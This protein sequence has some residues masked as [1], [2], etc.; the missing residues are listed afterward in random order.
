MFWHLTVCQQNYIIRN[1]I[2]WNRTDSHNWIASNRC[3]WQLNCVLILNCIVWNRTVYLYKNR[4]GI[5]ITYKGWYA[6]KPK[7]PNQPSP[8]KFST[9][10]RIMQIT[11]LLIFHLL[12][13]F[14]YFFSFSFSYSFPLYFSFIFPTSLSHF[15]SLAQ[16]VQCSPLVRET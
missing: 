2:V 14:F 3:F 15:F 10:S 16:W 13:I 12:F 9:S 6:I 1:W 5:K 11:L 8:F 4:W 7:Q